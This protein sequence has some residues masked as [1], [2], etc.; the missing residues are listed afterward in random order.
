MNDDLERYLTDARQ[1]ELNALA[2][3]GQ[4]MC[5]IRM[6]I[7]DTATAIL[8]ACPVDAEVQPK[9]NTTRL[10]VVSK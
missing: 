8:R 5:A 7:R 2:A 1:K 10:N 9:K 3:S 6:A 4:T